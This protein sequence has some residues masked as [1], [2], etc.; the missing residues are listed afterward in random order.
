MQT[1][2]QTP[3]HLTP[4]AILRSGRETIT[5]VSAHVTPAGRPEVSYL[6]D[7]KLWAFPRRSVERVLSCMG[8]A[9]AGQ[10]DPA[11]LAERVLLAEANYR[12]RVAA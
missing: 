10:E 1:T 5:I 2:P 11:V 4:G 12:A 9:P 6:A 7:D 8:F 3:L